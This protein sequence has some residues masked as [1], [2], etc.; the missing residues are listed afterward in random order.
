MS[1]APLSRR[2]IEDIRPQ[3]VPADRPELQSQ[4]LECQQEQ[5]ET[6]A[7][8]K[9]LAQALGDAR[10][11]RAALFVIHVTASKSRRSNSRRLSLNR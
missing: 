10:C 5:Y 3:L 7:R 4:D 2:D 9:C 11:Q 1:Q 8:R 6:D